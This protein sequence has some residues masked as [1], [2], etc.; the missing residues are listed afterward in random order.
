VTDQPWNL[1]D[2]D[3]PK[4]DYLSPPGKHYFEL[5]KSSF[6]LDDAGHTVLSIRTKDCPENTFSNT[7]DLSECYPCPD[8]TFS[9]TGAVECQHCA[10]NDVDSR[11]NSKCTTYFK[12]QDAKKKRVYMSIFIPVGIIFFVLILTLYSWY[13]FKR[14]KRKLEASDESWLLSYRKLTNPSLPHLSPQNTS[15]LEIPLLSFQAGKYPFYITEPSN[16]PLTPLNQPIHQ[17][18]S[19]LGTALGVTSGSIKSR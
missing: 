7:T 12:E 6:C 1:T 3:T 9:S 2:L 8:G 17:N 16:S 14:R 15:S 4:V 19:N 18:L 10:R 5:S 13:C 11:H